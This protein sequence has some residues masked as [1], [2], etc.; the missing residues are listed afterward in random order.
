MEKST[1]VLGGPNNTTLDADMTLSVADKVHRWAYDAEDVVSMNLAEFSKF[2]LSCAVVVLDER[3]CPAMSIQEF[4]EDPSG[5]H[6]MPPS[7][8]PLAAW[9]QKKHSSR[10]P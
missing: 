8:W 2:G 4:P 10:T 7:A 1:T 9:E 5:H 6:T 3:L